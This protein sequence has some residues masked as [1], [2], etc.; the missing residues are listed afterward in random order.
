MWEE[1]NIEN[2]NS[3]LNLVQEKLEN[4]FKGECISKIHEQSECGKLCTYH[5]FKTQFLKEPYLS[6]IK[7]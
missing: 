3:F 1:Q 7:I 2:C 5:I 6:V 4:N